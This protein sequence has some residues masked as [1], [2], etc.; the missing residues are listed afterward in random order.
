MVYALIRRQKRIKILEGIRN[1]A[2]EIALIPQ[3]AGQPARVDPTNSHNIAPAQ[4]FIKRKASVPCAG[5]IVPFA[6]DV[7]VCHNIGGG[8]FLFHA[9]VSNQRVGLRDDLAIIGRVTE[10]RLIGG[11]AGVKNHLAHCLACRAHGIAM[12]HCAVSEH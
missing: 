7:S 8:I 5:R 6:R 10:K 4:I 3:S 2:V 12:E 11:G 9:P 1:R